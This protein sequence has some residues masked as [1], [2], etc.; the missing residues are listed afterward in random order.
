MIYIHKETKMRFSLIS[1]DFRK[2]DLGEW[3]DYIV[4]IREEEPNGTHFIYSLDEFNEKFETN[5]GDVRFE[6]SKTIGRSHAS[7]SEAIKEYLSPVDYK[8]FINGINR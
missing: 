7:L 8:N 5:E 4:L 3:K 1:R 6:P 2:K